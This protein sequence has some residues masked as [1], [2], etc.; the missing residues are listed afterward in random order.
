MKIFCVVFDAPEFPTY[1]VI[2][3]EA[4]GRLPPGL[5]AVDGPWVHDGDEWRRPFEGEHLAWLRHGRPWPDLR[6]SR[7]PETPRPCGRPECFAHDGSLCVRGEEERKNC[8]MWWRGQSAK[9]GDAQPA[10]ANDE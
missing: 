1:G 9:V 7:D 5:P 6:D 10:E 3:S 8:Y 2:Q 4:G